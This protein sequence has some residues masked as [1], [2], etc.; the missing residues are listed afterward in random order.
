[1]ESQLVGTPEFERADKDYFLLLL[2]EIANSRDELD[3]V[4][5]LHGDISPARLDP[6]EHAIL[7]V[8]VAELMFHDDVPRNVVINEA[9]ELSKL[10]GAEGGYRFVNGVLDKAATGIGPAAVNG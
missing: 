8:A 10:F 2:G 9:I 3:A 7:W 1:V 5:E 6:V 4:L